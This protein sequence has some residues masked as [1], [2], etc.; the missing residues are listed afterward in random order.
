M[1]ITSL[2]LA[3]A[4]LVYWW[5][6]NHGHSDGFTLGSSGST[7]SHFYSQ[8]GRIALEATENLGSMVTRKIE[9]Y[10]FKNVI[11]YF[12]LI[13]GLWLAIKIRSWLPR[14]PG[15]GF[16]VRARSK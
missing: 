3:G 4:L 5:R 14:P 16:E 11:G 9:F 1:A 8:N 2:L 10:Q 13:P 12:L 6:S 15:R 7:Q